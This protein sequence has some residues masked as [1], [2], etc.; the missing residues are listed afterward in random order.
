MRFLKML[1]EDCE[2]VMQMLFSNNEEEE[3]DTMLAMYELMCGGF[4]QLK[5]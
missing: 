1:N 4:L 5:E 3:I 2:K